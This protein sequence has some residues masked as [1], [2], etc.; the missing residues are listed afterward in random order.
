M[1]RAGGKGWF[2]WKLEFLEEGGKGWDSCAPGLPTTRQ[3]FMEH[4]KSIGLL[5]TKASF[6]LSPL[7]RLFVKSNQRKYFDDQ[8]IKIQRRKL[9]NQKEKFA[10]IMKTCAYIIQTRVLFD[11]STAPS[12][13]P[14]CKIM[15]PSGLSDW[16]GFCG[17]RQ[18]G[19]FHPSFAS[20]DFFQRLHF[21][22]FSH[23]SSLIFENTN[24]YV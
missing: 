19:E 5:S 7:S 15:P 22:N 9:A 11:L 17:T 1:Q 23:S 4:E 16:V 6:T 13:K 14:L 21:H 10:L 20:S 18:S 12:R 8:M 24:L 2:N 3:E